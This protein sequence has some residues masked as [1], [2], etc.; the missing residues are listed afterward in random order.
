MSLQ[1]PN[2]FGVACTLHVGERADR[3]IQH[4]RN[5]RDA[6]DLGIGLPILGIARLLEQL[7]PR[8]VERGG[9]ATGLRFAIG[10]IGIEPHRCATAEGLLDRL[11]TPPVV[12][13]IFADLNLE[14]AEAVLQPLLHLLGNLLRGGAVERRKKR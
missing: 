13:R 10:T 2:I 4:D 5:G 9:K 12:V 6:G 7:D 3:L 8:R 11:D 1:K 14:G